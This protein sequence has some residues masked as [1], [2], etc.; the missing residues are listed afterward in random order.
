[1]A[2]PDEYRKRVKTLAIKL[3]KCRMLE[4]GGKI[5]TGW[6]DAR[7]DYLNELNKAAEAFPGMDFDLADDAMR[8]L[9]GAVDKNMRKRNEKR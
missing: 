5:H 6:L 1:M 2:A 3:A 7:M 8:E 4:K 9:I